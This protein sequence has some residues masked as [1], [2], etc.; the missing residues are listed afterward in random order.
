MKQAMALTVILVALVEA[1]RGVFGE[2]EVLLAVNGA[3]ALMAAMIASTFLWLWFQRTTPLA[4]G[5]VFA[6]SGA[7]V[8]VGWWWIYTL[9]G[10]ADWAWIPRG[11]HAVQALFLVGALLHFAVIHRSFGYHGPAF[12]WPVAL[13]LAL[14]I[15]VV[16]LA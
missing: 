4:L 12:L 5:M 10:H 15:L 6:W 1:G 7:A 8:F 14:S 11:A 2:A 16:A 9:S 3:M 13:S